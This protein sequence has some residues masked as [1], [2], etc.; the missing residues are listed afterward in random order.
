MKPNTPNPML[1]APFLLGLSLFPA[2][3][4]GESIGLH[5]TENYAGPRVSDGPAD[6][7]SNWTDS[8]DT[9]EGSFFANG[10]NV[11]LKGGGPV[12]ATW[13]SSNG[14][15]A[16]SEADNEK[17]LYR[18]YLDDG[19]VG[20]GTGVRV[21]LTKMARWLALNQHTSYQIRCY[22]NNDSAIQY[23]PISVRNGD[24]TGTVLETIT[25]AP[26]GDGNYPPGSVPT[27]GASRGY[28]DSSNT[29][30]ADTVSLTIA[31]RS[32]GIRG[33]LTAFKITGIGTGAPVDHFE[34]G[35]G[36]VSVVNAALG[37]AQTSVFRA[38]LDNPTVT[39]NFSVA[40]GHQVQVV[41][42]AGGFTV[43]S[44]NLLTLPAGSSVNASDFTLKTL[45]RGT[46]GALEIDTTGAN[47]VL[48]LTISALTIPAPLYWTGSVAG[49]V[50]DLDTAQNWSYQSASSGY[51]DGDEVIFDDTVTGTTSV[52]LNVQVLPFSVKVDN[53]GTHPYSITGTGAINGSG[54][55]TKLGA[56]PLTLGTA[57][58][59]SG[60]TL[61][62]AGKVTLG[63]NTALG[64]TSA[65]T[66]VLSDAKLDLN[67][68]NLGGEPLSLDGSG[69][70]GQGALV[71]NSATAASATGTITLSGPVTIGGS[72]DHTLGILTGGGSLVKTGAG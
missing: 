20:G 44:Y 24:I 13:Q 43:G 59:Y 36:T 62:E 19:N 68:M 53:D 55:F 1:R 11:S 22:G 65:G 18:S 2:T 7:F 50:W 3:L 17:A 45:P 48:K 6:L 57:N 63:S 16:G 66:T 40:A 60:A 28:I 9:A 69:G 64:S 8:C 56:G 4:L 29:L 30:A 37:A 21:T 14:W 23:R 70:D 46:T 42:P 31:S 72:G 15:Y 12:R 67:G 38:G 34:S 39:G 51:I 61:I 32:G 58:G 5:F 49:G 71:N 52:A 10:T 27:S 25:V 54:T 41:Q 33:T 47:P 35:D 26:L